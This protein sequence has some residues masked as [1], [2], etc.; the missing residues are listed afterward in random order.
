MLRIKVLWPSYVGELS[1]GDDEGAG[2]TDLHSV[3]KAASKDPW[4]NDRIRKRSAKCALI[5]KMK[6]G[7][8][9]TIPFFMSQFQDKGPNKGDY[10][11]EFGVF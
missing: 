3:F 4:D 8:Y 5:L 1:S 2:F 6:S 7:Y 11:G 9:Y 10:Y